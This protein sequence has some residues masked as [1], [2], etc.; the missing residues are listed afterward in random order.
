MRGG[1]CTGETS[2]SCESCSG[3]DCRYLDS[4]VVDME[5]RA[6]SLGRRTPATFAHS[7]KA[8][9]LGVHSEKLTGQNEI[10]KALL[11]DHQ[12]LIRSLAGAKRSRPG[13]DILDFVTPLLVLCN[14]N[15]LNKF[16]VFVIM[17][18]PHNMEVTY[19]NW[20]PKKPIILKMKSDKS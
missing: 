8:T 9:R 5:G 12:S 2:P 10:I 16:D 19:D 15:N 13:S 17:G 11:E 3:N 1:M 18:E 6:R 4:A 7:M 14:I 20:R